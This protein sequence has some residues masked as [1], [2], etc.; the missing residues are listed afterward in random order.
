MAGDYEHISESLA[1][2]PSQ[3]GEHRKQFP[4]VDILPDGRIRFTSFRQHDKYLEKTGFRKVPQKLKRLG[5]KTIMR[6]RLGLW[7]LELTHP[8]L[9]WAA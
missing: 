7:L 5:R 3:I 6:V 2:S 1:I 4:D 9:L 8:H